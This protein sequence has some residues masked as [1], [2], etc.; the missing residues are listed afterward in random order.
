MLK[1]FNEFT[2]NEKFFKSSDEKKE[3][4]FNKIIN[5]LENNFDYEELV[6]FGDSYF[7]DNVFKNITFT[8][9]YFPE[10]FSI[11]VTFSSIFKDPMVIEITKTDPKFKQ[12]EKIFEPYLL[13]KREKRRK[14]KEKDEEELNNVKKFR[15]NKDTRT[16]DNYHYKK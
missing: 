8:I 7:Y 1:K 3:D 14:L 10:Y 15:Q 4:V 5:E 6:D 13:T 9:D 16:W 12:L 2:V 11:Y